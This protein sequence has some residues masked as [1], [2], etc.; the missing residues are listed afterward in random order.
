MPSG[1][2]EGIMLNQKLLLSKAERI[3]E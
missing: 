1:L 3:D 2:T